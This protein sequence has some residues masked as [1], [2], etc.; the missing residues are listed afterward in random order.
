MLFAWHVSW[1]V[2]R[3]GCG[4]WQRWPGG[5]VKRDR[6]QDQLH[7]QDL[8]ANFFEQTSDPE[9]DPNPAPV[10]QYLHARLG[11]PTEKSI[12]PIGGNLFT[13]TVHA[14]PAPTAIPGNRQNTG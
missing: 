8:A 3:S 10:N 4:S 5:R 13:P 11:A 6:A 9:Q 7:L 2:R 1:R 14:P 12:N